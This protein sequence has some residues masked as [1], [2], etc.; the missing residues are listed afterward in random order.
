M[1]YRQGRPSP[2]ESKQGRFHS[3]RLHVGDAANPGARLLFFQK[4][5]TV[6][7]GTAD[8]RRMGAGR[9]RVQHRVPG[10]KLYADDGSRTFHQNPQSYEGSEKEREERRGKTV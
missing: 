3:H 4:G 2:S 8:V 10:A 9:H 5:G 6:D 7:E 1:A